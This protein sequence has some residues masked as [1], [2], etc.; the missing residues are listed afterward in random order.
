MDSTQKKTFLYNVLFLLFCGGLF[1][2]LWQ[3]PEETTAK[4]PFDDTHQK[5]YTMK[6]KEADAQC[7]SCHNPEGVL[8]LPESHPPKYRC[9]FCHKKVT[10]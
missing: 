10:Q 5:F 1:I 2:F 3:A 6:K 7:S 8:P 9:L 4:I